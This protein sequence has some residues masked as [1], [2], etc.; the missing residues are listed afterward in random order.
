MA[1]RLRNI[2]TFTNLVAGTPQSQPHLLNIEG[3]AVIPDSVFSNG[4]EASVA[5]DN[6]NITITPTANIA[7]LNVMVEYWYSPKRVFGV[8]DDNVFNQLAPAPFTLVGGQGA[9]GVLPLSGIEVTRPIV[10][11]IPTGVPTTVI[12]NQQ[13]AIQSPADYALNAGVITVIPTGYFGIFYSTNWATAAAAGALTTEITIGG[14]IN[15]NGRTTLPASLTTNV[16]YGNHIGFILT[17]LTAQISLTVTQTTGNPLNL[18]HA[19][20]AIVRWS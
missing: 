20:L 7:S 8:P 3:I 14:G 5:A 13:N 1:T 18:T 9:S 6:T 10:Q 2:L 19:A 11:S 4:S 15:P 17:G 16:E 12:L